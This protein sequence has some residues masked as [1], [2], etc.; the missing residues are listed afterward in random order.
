MNKAELLVALESKLTAVLS[1][2]SRS[3]VAGL[4]YY[5]ANVFDAVGDVGRTVNVMFFV[6]DEGG[7]GEVA[8]WGGSE[9][10][11]DPG[12]ATFADEA[13][14][15]LQSKVDVTVSGKTIRMFEQLNADNVQE[16]ATV[17]L[18]L[19]DTTTGD[20]SMIKVALW[21]AAGEFQYKVVTA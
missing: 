18:T 14:A 16:R 17:Y 1:I 9:P 19:E 5:V 3:E 6:K 2:E 7:A 13:R 11:P 12:P 10:K 15:W 8:Y 4:S 20:L 21:K